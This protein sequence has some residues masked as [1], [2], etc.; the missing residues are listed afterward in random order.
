M[1]L[2]LGCTC[3]AAEANGTPAV[4]FVKLGPSFVGRLGSQT[5]VVPESSVKLPEAF[6]A[7]KSQVTALV[8]GSGS[9]YD[10]PIVEASCL[11]VID[12]TPY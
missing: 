2:G 11:G 3:R 1:L 6:T 8:E 5:S 12:N 7:I 10:C 9:S 4:Y